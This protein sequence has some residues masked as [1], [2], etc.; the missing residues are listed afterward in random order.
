M[1]YGQI[2]GRIL[3]SFRGGSAWPFLG[4]VINGRIWMAAN[5]RRGAP[6]NS[7]SRGTSMPR[8]SVDGLDAPNAAMWQ[9]RQDWFEATNDELSGKGSHLL[10]EQ[11]CALLMDI[12]TC[13][14]SGAGIAGVVLSACGVG[15]TLR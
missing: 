7:W 12:Q 3:W 5:T 8:M 14:C 15:G 13:F 1:T 6:V 10:S 2:G 4:V 11:A 9:A